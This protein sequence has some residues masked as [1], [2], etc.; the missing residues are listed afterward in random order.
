MSD[1][2]AEAQEPISDVEEEE[3]ASEPVQEPD[4]PEAQAEG[5][6]EPVL[7]EPGAEEQVLS[8]KQVE[9]ALES[10]GKEATRH[11]NRVSEIMGEDALALVPCEL[12]AVNIPGFRFS[13]QPNEEVQRAVRAAIGLPTLETLKPD[14]YSRKC[15]TCDGAGKVLSGSL[16]QGRETLACVDCGGNGWKPVGQERQSGA[17]VATL[18]GEPAPLAAVPDDGIRRDMF[19]TPEG[20]PDFEKMPNARQRPISYWQE[21]QH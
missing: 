13:I 6:T 3:E 19:G 14:L 18:D 21:Q 17:P 7:A 9:K 11:A 2:V 8:E 1:T 12:C 4:E 20:D 10:L 16:V 15:D 5:Q